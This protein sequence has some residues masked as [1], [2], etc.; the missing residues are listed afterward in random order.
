MVPV[1]SF[2]FNATG[3]S[4]KFTD[5]SSGSPT[6]WLWDF[7]DTTSSALQDPPL[8]VFPADGV[9]VVSLKASNVDGENTKTLSLTITLEPGLNYSVKDLVTCDLPAGISFDTNCF[10]QSLRKWQLFLQPFAG[11]HDADVFNE[12]K[13]PPL[14]NVLLAKLLVYDQIIKAASTAMVTLQ[15]SAASQ[16]AEG[17]IV[18][19]K[20]PIKKIETGPS[21]VEWYDG[22]A[23]WTNMLKGSSGANQGGVLGMIQS[24]LCVFARRLGVRLPMC[25]YNPKQITLFQILKPNKRI[26]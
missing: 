9:Y 23:Y 8:H 1:A 4:V 5:R 26:C 22:S 20:G 25:N 17:G 10:G 24:D 18:T 2:I 16:T 19:T 14:W 7:G 13:W 3:L 12:S 15:T 6:A 21:N 11:I